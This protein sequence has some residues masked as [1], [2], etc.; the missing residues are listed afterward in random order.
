MFYAGKSVVYNVN[1][2]IS[3]II[4]GWFSDFI[5]S[6]FSVMKEEFFFPFSKIFTVN[7][8]CEETPKALQPRVIQ[9]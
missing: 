6:T 4:F 5:I 1:G 8:A 9:L 7:G 3:L 2:V